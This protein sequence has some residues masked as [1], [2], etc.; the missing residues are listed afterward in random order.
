MGTKRPYSGAARSENGNAT[1][2]GGR[3]RTHSSK[4]PR[5]RQ[6]VGAHDDNLAA[7][8]KRARALERLLA[9]DNVKIPADKQNELERELAAH[10]QRIAE[11]IARR[12]RSRMIQK[13]HMVRFFG[14]PKKI[15]KC[16]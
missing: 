2:N 6:K 7:I 5:K 9:R 3:S 8:K 14:K 16:S 11:A 4:H 10:K 1:S 12:H 15:F 13:Y